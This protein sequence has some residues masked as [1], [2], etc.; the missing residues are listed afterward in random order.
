MAIVIN[1][2][3]D[4]FSSIQVLE[5]RYQKP[6]K[7]NPKGTL[8]IR[9]QRIHFDEDDNKSWT[10]ESIKEVFLKDIDSHIFS[11]LGNGEASMFNAFEALQVA[12]SDLIDERTG[13]DTSYVPEVI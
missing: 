6:L 8:F 1:N 13:L 9:Y 4:A 7:Q 3:T 12:I 11:K 2:P 10:D 5:F